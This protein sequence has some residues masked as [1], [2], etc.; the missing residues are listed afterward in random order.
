MEVGLA[1]GTPRSGEPVPSQFVLEFA[2]R[3]LRLYKD[4]GSGSEVNRLVSELMGQGL[5]SVDFA[6][7]DLTSGEQRPEQWLPSRPRAAL[8]GF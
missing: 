2:W 6:H 7:R 3:G 5:R 4:I 8:S 1:D